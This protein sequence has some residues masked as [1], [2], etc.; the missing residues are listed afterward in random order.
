MQRKIAATDAITGGRE[1]VWLDTEYCLQG[2]VSGSYKVTNS[3]SLPP[4]S[5]II[6]L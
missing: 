3:L 2:S 4:F 1:G 6:Y 5:R